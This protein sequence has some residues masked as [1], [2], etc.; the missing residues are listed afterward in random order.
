MNVISRTQIMLCDEFHEGQS[1]RRKLLTI[2][3][4]IDVSL[5]ILDKYFLTNQNTASNPIFLYPN[6]WTI[7]IEKHLC[8]E[9]DKLEWWK[10]GISFIKIL[11]FQIFFRWMIM[12]LNCENATILLWISIRLRICRTKHNNTTY[13]STI[14]KQNF[15]EFNWC[16]PVSSVIIT[17]CYNSNSQNEE[18][19]F[20]GCCCLWIVN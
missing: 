13:P 12:L 6:L 1:T 3:I 17:F 11:F 10:Y 9:R 18:H 16:S 7:K 2:S 4:L 8:Y 20:I 15:Q 19:I 5:R 14:I